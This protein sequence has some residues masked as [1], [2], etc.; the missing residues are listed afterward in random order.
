A[1]LKTR[2]DATP[3]PDQPSMVLDP[4]V[5]YTAGRPVSVSTTGMLAYF[6]SPSIN[7]VAEWYDAAGH[8]IG[9]LEIPAGHYEHVDISPDGT[10]AIFVKST[11]PSESAL[12][13]VDL[14]NG[15]GVPVT[16][17]P[18]RNDSP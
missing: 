17:A 13:L 16:S 4:T 6:S 18:G 2:G 14:S 9:T 10:R 3:M 15:S 11:S 1:S 5:S 8:Q 12:W 7:T